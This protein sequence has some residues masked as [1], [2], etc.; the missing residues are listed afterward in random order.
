MVKKA[1]KQKVSWSGA[2]LVCSYP[3]IG[4]KLEVDSSKLPAKIFTDCISARHGLKQK[5][6]DVESGGTPQEKFAMA[7]RV[8]DTLLEGSWEVEREEQDLTPIICEAVSRI[9]KVPLDKIAEAAA[10]AGPEK[11]KEWGADLKVKAMIL[12]IRAERAEEA[13][14]ESDEELDIEV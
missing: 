14:E 6:V 5:F 13:A 4:K 7:Q 11:V 10:K 8:Y 3:S 2:L 9:K 1:K 12:K